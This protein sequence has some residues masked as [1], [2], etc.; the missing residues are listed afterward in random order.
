LVGTNQNAVQAT[1]C[2]HLQSIVDELAP[3]VTELMSRPLS[4]LSPSEVE[5]LVDEV[6]RH[7]VLRTVD[8]VVS[9]S[10]VI[11]EAVEAGRAR[12]VGAVYDVKSGEIEFL[13]EDVAVDR[14]GSIRA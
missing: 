1:G 6:A 2:E 10:S 14:V 11:R 5:S 7:N 4:E 9:R 3:S 12:V 8:E 13:D